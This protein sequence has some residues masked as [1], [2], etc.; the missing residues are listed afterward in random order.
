[1]RAAAPPRL[2]QVAVLDLGDTAAAE[3]STQQIYRSFG[4]HSTVKLLDR[5]QSRAAAR[6]I[7]YA[8][9]LNL[10]LA[11]ARDLGAALGCDFF[12]TGDAQVLRRTAFERPLYYEAYASIF[13][14]S[15]RTGQLILWDHVSCDEDTAAAAE[16]LLLAEIPRRAERYLLTAVKFVHDEPAE[17]AAAKLRAEAA[18][19]IEEMPGENETT[20]RGFRPPHPYRRLLPRYPE[21]ARRAERTAT[22]DVLVEIDA[23][24]EVGRVCVVRWGGFGLDEEVVETVKRLHFRPA[25]RD[26][27]PVPVRSLL[28]YN[29]RPPQKT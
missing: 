11:E 5:A 23:H 2:P 29:F 16:A 15:A 1:M 10:T 26:R 8:G 22:I 27:V 28:R 9:S 13:L 4:A 20:A 25:T 14:V 21:I 18:V 24:G 12:I 7:A 19:L 6:G 3:R 17:R